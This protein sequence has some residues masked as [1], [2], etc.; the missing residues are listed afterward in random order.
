MFTFKE[1]VINSGIR[2]LADPNVV[3]IKDSCYWPKEI[4]L[5]E[6]F[7]PKWVVQNNGVDGNVFFGF[8]YK[9]KSYVFS[10]NGGNSF[11]LKAGQV[12]NITGADFT[13]QDLF[14]DIETFTETQT[15]EIIF[16]T[17]FVIG[18]GDTAQY[19]L[20]DNWSCPTYVKVSGGLP[21][22]TWMLAAGAGLGLLL[23]GGLALSR[24]NR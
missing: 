2:S 23:V 18:T 19:S 8:T 20:T 16:V 10:V 15:I 12:A 9:G 3:F 11:L 21:V 5:T 7:N 13:I 17:G 6:K 14:K 1:A 4:G 24:R 22:P